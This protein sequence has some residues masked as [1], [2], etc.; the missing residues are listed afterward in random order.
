MNSNNGWL[1]T[2]SDKDGRRL[3]PILEN[4]RQRDNAVLICSFGSDDP[5]A[6]ISA[7]LVESHSA[8]LAS[9]L[10]LLAEAG[11]CADM[12][13]YAAELDLAALS[14]RLSERHKVTVKTGPSSP[15]LREPT[16]LYSVIDTGVIRAG[17]AEE[18]YK[19]TYL[20][21]GYQGRPTLIVDA[22]TVY[23]AYRLSEWL[24]MTKHITVIGEGTDVR[25]TE[26]GVTLETVLG[27]TAG[28]SRV[29]AGGVWG[30][31]LNAS[32]LSS[33]VLSYAYLYDSIKLLGEND[34]VVSETRELYKIATE[35]S[36][37]KCVLCREGSWQLQTIFKDMADG[38][39]DRDDIPL[40]ED[41]CPLISAGALCTFGKHM[42]S[43][44][45][46]AVS[47]CRGE[48]YEHIVGKTCK[49]GKCRGLMSYLI[50]PSLCT[51][52][53]DC[54]DSCQE[55]AIEGVDGFIHMIDEKLCVKCGKCL[56]ACPEGA[57]K[58][59]GEKVK[60]PKKL[61]RVGKFH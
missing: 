42:I 46:S 19:R 6:P 45:L 51:G 3:F 24:G 26:V 17:N 27:D 10:E 15:V 34:C 37:Q 52:C 8:Q 20:S 43:P 25:E 60:I 18:E 57:V 44:A 47:A 4:M 35:L 41:I 23:Q 61:T 56:P 2:L 7:H 1:E 28:I 31:Y 39:A 5:S 50:D 30:T 11:G 55:E 38:K 21:Y 40:I 14:E 32:D 59:G 33:T 22:E 48:V 53:G 9:G 36:C 49:A 54:L 12:I 16:A 29:L 58:F 13:F